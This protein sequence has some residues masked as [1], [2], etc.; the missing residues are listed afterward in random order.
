MQRIALVVGASTGLGL[1]LA[2]E[3]LARDWQVIAT[4]RSDS[5]AL[6]ELAEKSG[7]ALR[8]GLARRRPVRRLQR[9]GSALVGRRRPNA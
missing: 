1:G 9:Q 2:R 5:A 3:L 7:G 8:A 4:E 6:H